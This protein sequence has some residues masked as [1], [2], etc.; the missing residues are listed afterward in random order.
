MTLKKKPSILSYSI[1][2]G[3]VPRDS[4]QHSRCPRQK[5]MQVQL[6]ASTFSRPCFTLPQPFDTFPASLIP[7]PM[8]SVQS[9]A[10]GDGRSSAHCLSAQSLCVCFSHAL[11]I[12]PHNEFWPDL[13]PA[14]FLSPPDPGGV[15][16]LGL[17]SVLR[18]LVFSRPSPQGWPSAVMP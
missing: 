6:G 9:K 5:I 16:R 11:W 4:G 13:R 7:I 2:Q 12:P 15:T 18:K 10:D 17:T 3:A 8:A 14:T 1:W